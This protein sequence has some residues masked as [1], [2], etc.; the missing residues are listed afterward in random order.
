MA[1]RWTWVPLDTFP[2][3]GELLGLT[4]ASE[5]GDVSRFAAS[6]NPIGYASLT[7][8]IN[9]SGDRSVTGVLSKAG[10]PTLRRAAVKAA[11]HAWRDTKA[12]ALH[13]S[14][15]ARRQEPL[16]A[17]L[18]RKILIA[19]RHILSRQTRRATQAAG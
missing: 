17:A 11:Q 7:P 13:R 9:Q 8:K 5:I 12:P 2:G 6:R 4:L 1:S 14:G 18:A 10:S 16:K 15:P 19:A 3:V